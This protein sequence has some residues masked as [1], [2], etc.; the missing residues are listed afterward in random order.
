MVVNKGLA[1]AQVLDEL[2]SA[3][4]EIDTSD[5]PE[6]IRYTDEDIMNVLQIFNH[7]IGN[8]TIHR[9]ID[10]NRGDKEYVLCWKELADWFLKVTGVNSRTYYHKNK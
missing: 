1:M 8:F 7:V 9:M 4:L 2:A 10:E 3:T 5:N 6:K